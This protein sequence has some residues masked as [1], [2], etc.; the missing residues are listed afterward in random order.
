MPA[1]PLR[2]DEDVTLSARATIAPV[3]TSPH[4]AD[5][6]RQRLLRL[7]DAMPVMM[8]V[9][10]L[11]GRIRQAN[12]RLQALLQ[13]P[14]AA[15]VGRRALRLLPRAQR[16][17]VLEAVLRTAHQADACARQPLR[18]QDAIGGWHHLRFATVLE[19]DELQQPLHWLCTLEDET[20]Q[21]SAEDTL[22]LATT[23]SGIGLWDWTIDADVFHA[24]DQVCALWGR[25]PTARPATAP[26]DAGSAVAGRAPDTGH[27]DLRPLTL[28]LWR[29]GV[30]VDDRAPLALALRQAQREQQPVHTEF[31]VRWPDGQL[32]HL[33]LVGRPDAGRDGTA[34][35]RGTV[36]DVTESRRLASE[37]AEQ[38]ERLRVTLQSIGDAVLTTDALGLLSWMNPAAER[39]IAWPLAEALGRPL[40]QVLSLH[41]ERTHAPLHNPVEACLRGRPGRRRP[42]AVLIAR[43]GREH[44]IEETTAPIRG[45]TGQVL[46]AVLVLRD[47]TEQRRLSAEMRHRATHDPLTDLVNRS[48]FEQR[49]ARSLDD[50]LER[51]H[52]H[53]LLYLDLDQFKLVNDSCGHAAGDE[54]LRQVAR[55]LADGVRSRDTLARLGGDEFGLILEHCTAEQA[56]Q[57]AQSLCDRVERYRYTHQGQR[58][59]VGASIGLVPIDSR[60]PT[61]SAVLQA[62][63]AA[64]YAAKEAGRN[65]VQL[66]QDADATL[67]ARHGQTQWAARLARAL[68]EDR[69]VLYAQRIRSLHP[70]R[71]GQPPQD[72]CAE[73]LLRLVAEDGS[74]VAP[75]AFLPAA[76]RFH[77]ASR[78]DR[79]VMARGLQALAGL[80][81]LRRPDCLNINLSGQSIGDRS[82]HAWA[83]DQLAT[84]GPDICARLC[85]EITE[86]AAVTH[87]ADAETFIRQVRS[88]GVRVAL[89]DFGAGASSF[90]YLKTM[91]VDCLKIDGQYIRQL[92]DSPLDEAA[93]RCFTEVAR[94]MGLRT[95]A[96]FVERSEVLERL[97]ALG[98]DAAQ[99]WLLHRPEPLRDL[100]DRFESER[101]A[102][103][104]L[105]G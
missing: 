28:N 46:G 21:R 41:D 8:L 97:Q 80:G 78:I 96:E 67:H 91:T 53:A 40:Q 1:V 26:A 50:A 74:L 11:R 49:L 69:F 44:G 7:F 85:L 9:L 64:C 23:H 25:P 103:C 82:F 93:V 98:V 89:D 13:R 59:A 45:H 10:D 61:P 19:R 71:P 94:V 6:T 39:L 100:L 31:R 60:W 63:D 87:V 55:L 30:H 16:R 57:I 90:G 52:R 79:W 14:R 104:Q 76:E 101:R 17:G 77:L 66:W 3:A 18:V 24:D 22:R 47:V 81:P 86:T 33:Q 34:H 37:L 15:L 4:V 84:A 27:G 65:R 20:P 72:C 102:A 2:P 32:R 70:A 29:E 83:V 36:W 35:L 75:G 42:P 88:A 5:A 92:T 51:G 58:F 95:V 43:D 105:S 56:Q 62:A 68:D 12:G 38:H 73:L 48:E 99:G 54:L